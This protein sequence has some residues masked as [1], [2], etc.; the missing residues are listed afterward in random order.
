M[1]IG[2]T[3]PSHHTQECRDDAE[4][5]SPD[6]LSWDETWLAI[7]SVGKVACQIAFDFDAPVPTLDVDYHHVDV[8]GTVAARSFGEMVGWWIEALEGGAWAYDTELDVWELREDQRGFRATP[9]STLVRS[10]HAGEVKMVG[11]SDNE[12]GALILSMG[13]DDLA[14][15]VDV[16]RRGR[17]ADIPLSPAAPG[18]V[19]R[20]VVRLSLQPREAAALL[21][22]VNSD[23]ATISGSPENLCRWAAELLEF[24]REND[25]EEP[26]MHVHFDSSDHQF[27]ELEIASESVE[28]VVTG[29]I[30]D[31]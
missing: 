21:V 11:A 9:M 4:H 15:L 6:Y 13:K 29:P 27:R 18:P 26:G 20:P 7:G 19:T 1:G 14:F 22:T 5:D 10:S 25:L 3:A 2:T 24:E 12:T 16:L 31:Q 8:P 30:S 28:L 17:A 23:H